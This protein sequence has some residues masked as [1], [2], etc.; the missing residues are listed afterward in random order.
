MIH[1]RCRCRYMLRNIPCDSLRNSCWYRRCSCCRNSR[2]MPSSPCTLYR[3]R[4]TRRSSLHM[5]RC[6]SYS[7]KYTRFRSCRRSRCNNCSRCIRNS[8]CYIRNTPC[9]RYRH[10][11]RNRLPCR[12]ICCLFLFLR[13]TH[14]RYFLS[15]CQR[16]PEF[17]P[18][19]RMEPFRKATPA[20]SK[21]GRRYPSHAAEG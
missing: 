17:Y 18:P 5:R 13:P 6:S 12:K 16:R 19:Y 10:T 15:C 11:G 14:S 1:S 2:S 3:N 20:Q 4:C 9:R 21:Q 7:R 8:W